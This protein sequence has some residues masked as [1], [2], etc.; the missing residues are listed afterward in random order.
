MSPFGHVRRHLSLMLSCFTAV[1]L[2][3]ANEICAATT[4]FNGPAASVIA[5]IPIPSIPPGGNAGS[6]DVQVNTKTNRIYVTGQTTLAVL[7]GATDNFIANVPIP[8]ANLTSG[9]GFTGLYQSCV[10]DRTNTIYA[11]A[12]V[13][14]VTAIDGATNTIASTFAPWPTVTVAAVDGIVCNPVT[15]KLYMIL[16]NNQGP[17][18]V[19]WDIKARNI[20]ATL[21]VSRVPHE[22]M[23]VN[24]R[25]NR[26]YAQTLSDG[27]VVIDGATDTVIDKIDAGQ[28]PQPPGCLVTGNCVNGGSML[29]Q[30]AVNEET[31]RIYVGGIADGSLTTIDGGTNKAIATDYFDWFPYSVA[32]DPVR[33]RI[34]P[35]DITLDVL[36]IVDGASGNPE[37]VNDFETAGV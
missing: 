30:V 14:V 5:T 1:V 17:K 9:A 34:Y 2:M 16:Y 23:A 8:A 12:E 18:I 4:N 6:D 29:K 27:V 31:N 19:V 10:D 37:R 7:D 20:L 22:W 21:T 32:V 36:S 26:I 28:L 24:R 11:I 35:V 3:W 13:G 33:N 15:G 25:T